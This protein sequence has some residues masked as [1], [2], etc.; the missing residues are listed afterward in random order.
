[1][2]LRNVAKSFSFEEQRQE[3]NLL[4]VDVD[5]IATNIASM[6]L[7]N[8]SNPKLGANLDLNNNSITGTGDINHNGQLTT[9]SILTSASLNNK[10]SI[11]FGTA[12][13]YSLGH[14]PNNSN[15]AF[16]Q[17][18]GGSYL[19]YTD[20]STIPLQIDPTLVDVNVNLDVNG[21]ITASGTITALG[22]NSTYW[23]NAHSWGDHSLAGYLTSETQSD[24]NESDTSN[25]AHILNKPNLFDGTWGS[26]S[27]KPTFA[28]VATSGDYNDLSNTPT[29]A[30]Q[31]QSNWGETD[32]NNV[33]FIKNKPTI[34]TIPSN[35]SAFNNDVGY[36]TTDNNTTYTLDAGTHGA[37]DAKLT[38][39]GSTSSIDN[40]ILTAGTGIAFSSIGSGGF[41]ISTSLSIGNLTDVNVSGVTTGQVLKWSG[42]Q[43]APADD[44]QGSGGGGFSGD[45]NDL[46]NK[47][48]LYTNSDVNAHLNTS[49]AGTGQI[50]SWNGS[51]YD[52]VNDQQ[53]GSG[54]GSN[55][56]SLND[57]AWSGLNPN[58]QNGQV[59]QHNGSNWTNNTL[60]L[61]D[62]IEDLSD[63]SNAAPQ[64]GHIL[65]WDAG[66]NV[67]LP[68][69]DDIDSLYTKL[70]A[71]GNDA[72]ITTVAGL[73]SALAALSR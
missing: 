2:V 12:D 30:S 61:P 36:K 67:W 22:G 17:L 44:T 23:N 5:S 57:V 3:I 21:T 38:L 10:G 26:L 27:G 62:K 31:V 42:T 4:A 60:D 59:L 1:M 18:H 69:S 37:S 29:Q 8:E 55:L 49:T 19:F 71:I 15:F 11:Q 63:V 7:V 51:D 34:P 50:L 58:P 25:P 39:L 33:A 6:T 41:T 56:E 46:T 28:T 70:N 20:S 47:P 35:V 16:S 45:Y 54:S 14:M 53:G 66:N 32:S 24:W 64:D 48:T 40:V 68:G 9:G 13:A 65:R 52:W 43:W 73:K 72:S